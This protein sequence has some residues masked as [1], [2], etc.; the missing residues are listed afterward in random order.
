MKS[1]VRDQES[2]WNLFHGSPNYGAFQGN[3]IVD[4]GFSSHVG[5]HRRFQIY[6]FVVSMKDWVPSSIVLVV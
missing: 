3:I 1:Y 6:D 4:V 5:S 2:S